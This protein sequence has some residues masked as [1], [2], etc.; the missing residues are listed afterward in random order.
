MP[1]VENMDKIDPAQLN[2]PDISVNSTYFTDEYYQQHRGQ[3]V[4]DAIH[5]HFHLP[6]HNDSDCHNITK[7]IRE[8][9][10]G[11]AHD[12]STQTMINTNDTK[13]AISIE[14][15]KSALLYIVVVLSFYAFGIGLMMIK[16][17]RQEAKEQEECKRYRRYVNAA[18]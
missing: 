4:A 14:S 6:G 11:L 2:E 3:L 13:S 15:Q 9:L 5:S 17:M 7:L 16:Y 10:M 12:I 18:H 1:N 8:Y